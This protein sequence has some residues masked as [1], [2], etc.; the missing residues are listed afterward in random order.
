MT[1]ME[2]R[3]KLFLLMVL[4]FNA[5]DGMGN[6]ISETDQAG[7]TTRFEYDP[8]GRLVKVIDALGNET[9]YGYD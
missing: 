9:V 6:K 4:L 7:K 8:S 5:Y 3:Q 1:D 2:G